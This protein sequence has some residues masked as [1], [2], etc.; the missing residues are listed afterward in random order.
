MHCSDKVTVVIKTSCTIS[1]KLPETNIPVIYLFFL[2]VN[3]QILKF[4]MIKSEH[5]KMHKIIR[6]IDEN[7]LK[8]YEASMRL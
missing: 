4:Y 2:C 6:S 3:F 8:T 5:L 7:K 1:T